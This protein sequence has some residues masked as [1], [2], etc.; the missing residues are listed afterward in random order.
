MKRI[1]TLAI[2]SVVLLAASAAQADIVTTVDTNADAYV[3]GANPDV[4]CGAATTVRVAGNWND[5]TRTRFSYLHFDLDSCSAKEVTV[6]KL[7][8]DGQGCAPN[9][10]W[11]AYLFAIVDKSKDWDLTTLSESEITWNNA[12]QRSGFVFAD[13]GTAVLKLGTVYTIPTGAPDIELDVTDLVKWVLGQNNS[14]TTF[15]D[16]D[17]K[18]TICTVS[19]THLTL[20]TILRV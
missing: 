20:P 14:Y 4:N 13:E 12:P 17:D 9:Q 2:V 11:A 15:E 6:A 18:L 16:S 1:A 10:N 8:L 7:R 19:Y 3:D 5:Q